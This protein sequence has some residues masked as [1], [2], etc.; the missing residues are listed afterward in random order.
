MEIAIK[1]G[2]VIQSYRFE[3]PIGSGAYGVVWQGRHEL[4]NLPVAIK[5]IDTRDLDM[6]NLERVRQEC[7]IGGQLTHREYV[8][9]VRNAFQEGDRLFIVMELMTGGSLDNYLRQCP[10]PDLGLTLTWALDLCAALE[11]V[12][13]LDVVHRDI[14]PQNIL[15]TDED[16][17]KL[18]DFG[19][20]HLPESSLTTVSQPGSP[21]Y[22]APEQEA[23]QPVDGGADVYALCAVFFEVWTGRKYFRLRRAGRDDV[24]EE[25]ALLLTEN[26]PH[27]SPAL[28]D[29]LMDAVLSGLRPHAARVSLAG[30]KAD[31][32]A[33]RA[34]WQSGK[35]DDEIVTA[36]RAR[37]RRRDRWEQVYLKC[38]TDAYRAFFRERFVHQ[39]M[40][41]VQVPAPI[42]PAP[43]LDSEFPSDALLVELVALMDEEEPPVQKDEPPARRVSNEPETCPITD[44]H[45][46][47][48]EY[49]TIALLGEPGS[50]KTSALLWL[51]GTWSDACDGDHPDRLPVFVS[52]SRYDRG[53]FKD[54]LVNAWTPSL[55]GALRADKDRQATLDAAINPMA[56]RLGD[57]LAEGRVVLLL[58]A[59]NELPRGETHRERLACLRYFVEEAA[60][61]GNW[62]V[63]SCRQQDYA[64]AL[65]PLQRVEIRPLDDE[66]IHRFLVAYLDAEVG[67]TLWTTLGESRYARLRELIRN[68]FL[69]AGLVGVYR[70]EKGALPTVRMA[71]LDHLA[72]LSI[73]WEKR[74]EH[75]GWV[76]REEQEKVL[77]ALALAMTAM[78]RTVMNKA[79]LAGRLPDA[80]FF[81]PG[82]REQ[83][84]DAVLRLAVGAQLAR[85][86]PGPDGGSVAF[87]HQVWQEYYAARL[88]A[89]MDN[90]EWRGLARYITGRDE[91]ATPFDVLQPHLHDSS[92]RDVVLLTTARLDETG[93]SVFIDHIL[94]ADSLWEEHLYRDALLTASCLAEGASVRPAV[95]DAVLARLEAARRLGIRPLT[96]RVDRARIAALIALDRAGD[97]L[98][99]SQDRDVWWEVR[100]AAAKALETMGRADEATRV[101]LAMAQNRQLN[102]KVRQEAAERLEKAGCIDAAVEAWSALEN[103]PK[104]GK[105]LRREA[106]RALRRLR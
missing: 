36:A 37:P 91:V 73:G 95:A 83:L 5:V 41:T 103:D 17:V 82:R 72:A 25:M 81:D 26:Y 15:L 4:L 43:A 42:A 59:L 2:E 47:M 97:L 22:R 24:R 75:P 40:D 76:T 39:A 51:L 102:S 54:F 30:L 50:G 34:D 38:L 77:A 23:N 104:A 19:V 61:L 1:P 14:K 49:Q 94:H 13:A 90:L 86:T 74:K 67:D 60:R 18:S 71:L 65:R 29:Q 8:V 20:A 10:Y 64:E 16:Q 66:R 35:P 56:A 52:L 7:R 27:L 78:G 96:R 62:V 89:G 106:R 88:L 21:G 58:D 85:W 6:Q 93:A 92:W 100:L 32:S 12:H 11:E 69:L 84:L 98:A 28:R 31:L 48:A 68:P 46:G 99:L 55:V 45:T 33:I 63:V 80:W 9:E 57:Y 3:H 79:E 101:W 53:T 70:L 44:L 105:G 87:E